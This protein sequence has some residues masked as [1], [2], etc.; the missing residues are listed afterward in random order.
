[1]PNRG[2]RVWMKLKR[3]LGRRLGVASRIS[4]FRFT[5]KEPVEQDQVDSDDYRPKAISEDFR[6]A[7]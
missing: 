6:Q 3:S 4:F 5:H 7:E 1:V 2:K